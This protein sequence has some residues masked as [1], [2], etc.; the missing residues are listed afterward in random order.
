MEYHDRAP[1]S[2]PANRRQFLLT[3]G[4]TMAAG[5]IAHSSRLVNRFRS[6]KHPKRRTE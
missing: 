6:R 3:S 5:V 1:E 4:S 2:L